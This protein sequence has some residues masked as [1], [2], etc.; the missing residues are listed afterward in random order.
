MMFYE[1]KKLREVLKTYG[2][3]AAS[4][5]INN[6]IKEAE[7]ESHPQT[8][9]RYFNKA[10]VEE[11]QAVINNL[12][13][14]ERSNKEEGEYRRAMA[15]LEELGGSSQQQAGGGAG[16]RAVPPTGQ[17]TAAAKPK[18]RFM[19]DQETVK[20]IQGII[21][22]KADG[23]WG[24]NTDAAWKA[25]Y[26]NKG[27]EAPDLSGLGS[28]AEAYAKLT[29]LVRPKEEAGTD[30]TP[31]FFDRA[32]ERAKKTE[33]LAGATTTEGTGGAATEDSVRT[34]LDAILGGRF[35]ISRDAE[36]RTSSGELEPSKIRGLGAG[37]LARRAKRYFR[38]LRRELG[39]EDLYGP[40]LEQMVSKELEPTEQ[41]YLGVYEALER[42]ALGADKAGKKRQRVRRRR[43]AELEVLMRK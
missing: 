2:R 8:G 1:L 5:A 32:R 29:E 40:I 36:T 42:A 37:R 15:R 22:A 17:Q 23:Y 34:A 43:K 33:E 41:F 9:D 28:A 4:S 19:N 38:K 6:M 25:R 14:K 30:D 12:S 16:Q 31:G 26:E 18:Y 10:T 13:S 3:G 7:I 11:A 27:Y 35:E 24:A 20:K 21:G 39:D